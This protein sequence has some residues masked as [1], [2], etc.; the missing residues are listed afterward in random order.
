M[1]V[2]MLKNNEE[3]I[4]IL[5]PNQGGIFALSIL[6]DEKWYCEGEKAISYTTHTSSDSEKGFVYKEDGFFIGSNMVRFID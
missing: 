4:E 2:S 6:G 1:S 5:L 3:G